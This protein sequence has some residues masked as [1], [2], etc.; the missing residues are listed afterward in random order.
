MRCTEEIG[1]QGIGALFSTLY[2][3]VQLRALFFSFSLSLAVLW[4]YKLNMH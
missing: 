1:P 2:T 3:F 4:V